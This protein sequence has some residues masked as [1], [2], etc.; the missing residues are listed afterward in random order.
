MRLVTTLL[1]IMT[2]MSCSSCQALAQ[3]VDTK[4]QLVEIEGTGVKI[5]NPKG[6][7]KATAFNGFQQEATNSSVMVSVIP[8]PFAAV[9]K[10]FTEQALAAQGIQL[11]SKEEKKL[12][13]KDGLLLKV[14]QDAYGQ[15]F[16]KWIAVF[17]DAAKTTMVAATFPA[18]N[19]D[20]NKSLHQCIMSVTPSDT[21]SENPSLP[22]ELD[23]VE[24]LALVE[25]MAAMGKMA[26]YSKNGQ[27][28][29]AKQTDPI[30]IVAPSFSNVPT[31][32]AKE[33]AIQRLRKT[34]GTEIDEIRT[35]AD[36]SIDGISGFA[37]DAT[38]HLSKSAEKVE[39]YQVM[40]F[41]PK[42]GYYLMTGLV[43]QEASEEFIPK[44]KSLAKSL[45]L[46][47]RE[48]E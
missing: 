25:S 7:E 23:D 10:G 46:V 26:A 3:A 30:F 19:A 27:L 45:K 40:L 34:A 42:G 32:D 35:V 39:L 8:G 47:A 13:G 9:T 44:F 14:A 31:G 21:S 5:Q 37:I 41:P 4:A 48:S 12:A 18:S 16:Q 2:A 17:G 28:P 33:F 36:I 43:G 20:L 15:K 24:G 6:F 29:L 22:F 1:A 38:G 11:I